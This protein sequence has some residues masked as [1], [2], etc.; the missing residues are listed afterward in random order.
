M[1][2]YPWRQQDVNKIFSSP[3][4]ALQDVLVDGMTIMSGGFGLPG[5]A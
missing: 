5:N 4:T 2:D 3:E 1:L